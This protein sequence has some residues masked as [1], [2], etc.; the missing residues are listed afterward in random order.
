MTTRTH[1]PDI[2]GV[3]FG[4]ESAK[5]RKFGRRRHEIDD[6]ESANFNDKD[7]GVKNNNTTQHKFFQIFF[8][9]VFLEWW[10]KC[11]GSENF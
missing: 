6:V 8:S 10:G 2:I 1:F 3:C 9:P 5:I 11:F 4:F 7:D